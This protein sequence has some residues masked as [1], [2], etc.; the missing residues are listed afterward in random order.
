MGNRLLKGDRFSKPV[1]RVSKGSEPKQMDVILDDD[2][3][4]IFAEYKKIQFTN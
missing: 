2:N 3:Q 1:L 4:Q